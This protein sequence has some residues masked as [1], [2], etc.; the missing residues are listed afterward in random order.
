MVDT[1]A[2]I[3]LGADA[4]GTWEVKATMPNEKSIEAAVRRGILSEPNATEPLSIRLI[5]KAE[6][7]GHPDPYGYLR[8]VS[9]SKLW[10]QMRQVT[11][12]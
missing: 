11:V 2:S 9:L 12:K 8:R 4:G 6:E 7:R 1:T 5:K 10:T 3:A